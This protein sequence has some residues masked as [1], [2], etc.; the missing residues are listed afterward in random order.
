M[1][2]DINTITATPEAIAAGLVAAPK[3]KGEEIKF[4][5]AGMFAL[6]GMIGFSAMG[7]GQQGREHCR[8]GVFR[9]IDAAKANGM[10][11]VVGEHIIRA[12]TDGE[13]PASNDE[14]AKLL[15]C[16]ARIVKPD[17]AARLIA[18]EPTH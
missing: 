3:F 17:S 14:F 4:T 10:P 13:N 12:F 18:G 1:L 11:H 9:V 2:N 15:Q 6:A 7:E 16:V 8:R 5:D